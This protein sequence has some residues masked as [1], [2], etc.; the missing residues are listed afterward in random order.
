M[1]FFKSKWKPLEIVLFSYY[2]WYN[3]TQ[4]YNSKG[5]LSQHMQIV[6]ILQEIPITKKHPI[7]KSLKINLQRNIIVTLLSTNFLSW[8]ID[9]RW[10]KVKKT[11]N[12]L[13]L[14]LLEDDEWR[15]ILSTSFSLF[16]SLE[17]VEISR[18]TNSFSWNG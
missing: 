12:V 2:W 4:W 3:I 15:M 8:Q 11:K 6:W 10:K 5:L 17:K 13:K 1:F 16:S 7:W 9:P 14:N 18:A